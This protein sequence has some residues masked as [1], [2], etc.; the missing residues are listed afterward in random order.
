MFY[1]ETGEVILRLQAYHVYKRPYVTFALS[2]KTGLNSY[3]KPLYAAC[4]GG[5]PEK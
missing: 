1:N 3:L 4:R 2:F 5:K